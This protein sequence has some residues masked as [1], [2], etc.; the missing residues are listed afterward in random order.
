MAPIITA[1]IS[2]GLGLLG[3]AV[4]AKGQDVIEKK[5]GVSLDTTSKVELLRLQQE[6]EEF[7]LEVAVQ[8][9]EMELE[10]ER[11]AQQEITKRWSA[12][13]LSDSW[14]SKNIRPAVLLLLLTTY[15]M[16]A[17]L[18]AFNVLVTESYVELLA[19]MLM[20]VMGAYFAGRTI[21]KI[22]DMRER[23]KIE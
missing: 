4:L 8:Q 12:D 11:V 6:H 14:L 17:L 13:M 1:L 20:L 18:S 15:V 16:F 7:L 21:E 3:N 22:V 9:A 10:A 2:Q 23:G 5:L 19:Q